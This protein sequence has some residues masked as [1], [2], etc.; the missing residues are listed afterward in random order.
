MKNKLSSLNIENIK[1]IIMKLSLENKLFILALVFGGAWFAGMFLN[2]NSNYIDAM[3]TIV[4][5]IIGAFIGAYK[6]K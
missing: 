3:R 2:I 6:R 4:T 1:L 5:L